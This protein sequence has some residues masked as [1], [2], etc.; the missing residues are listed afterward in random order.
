MNKMCDKHLE[1]FEEICKQNTEATTYLCICLYFIASSKWMWGGGIIIILIRL[2]PSLFST[3]LNP[4]EFGLHKR[5]WILDVL[6]FSLFLFS[7]FLSPSFPLLFLT[8][9]LSF[10]SLFISPLVI[11]G[12]IHD[13]RCLKSSRT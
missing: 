12:L 2:H 1:Q 4:C 13:Y 7:S 11:K 6:A 8:I 3:L 5:E 10:F 9:F